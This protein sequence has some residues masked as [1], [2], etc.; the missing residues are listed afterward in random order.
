MPSQAEGEGQIG[1]MHCKTAVVT[2]AT[3]GIGL[4]SLRRLR[5]NARGWCLSRNADRGRARWR[6][7]GVGA[8]PARPGGRGSEEEVEAVIAERSRPSARGCS[9]EQRQ[10]VPPG[11]RS[12]PIQRR[13]RQAFL[14]ATTRPLA[15][16]RLLT[17]ATPAR[18]IIN[19][20]STSDHRARYASD[21]NA[22]KAASGRPR[23][24]ANE[25]S[26]QTSR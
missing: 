26:R 2:G 20:A 21:Y 16:S 4:A 7:R 18:R 25:W 19:F 1:L 13:P 14:T 22:A 8:G 11:S 10:T 23:T 3:Q 6:D 12:R 5:G 9:G 17:C 15:C 24:A